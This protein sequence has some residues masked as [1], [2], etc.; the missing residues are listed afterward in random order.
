MPSQR[1]D[2]FSLGHRHLPCHVRLTQGEQDTRHP[3]G[4]V[5]LSP[6]QRGG[7]AGD[8]LLGMD[9]PAAPGKM[10]RCHLT[11]PQLQPPSSFAPLLGPVCRPIAA[12]YGF[13]K[14]SVQVSSRG[15]LHSRMSKDAVKATQHKQKQK[16]KNTCIQ[17][18]LQGKATSDNW[19]KAVSKENL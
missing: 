15:Q 17:N 11:C 7:R 10:A 4:S 13:Q 14:P 1:L 2:P 19:W 9:L 8:I 16:Q 12:L 3:H 6:F 18:L 5:P